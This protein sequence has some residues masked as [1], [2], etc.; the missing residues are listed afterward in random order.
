MILP[1]L[2]GHLQRDFMQ[3]RIGDAV[4]LDVVLPGVFAVGDLGEQFITIDVAAFIEDRLETGLDLLATEALEQPA[5]PARAHQAGL[6]LAVEI[7]R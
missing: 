3:L 5:H 2:L 7:G 6:D 4:V 1:P